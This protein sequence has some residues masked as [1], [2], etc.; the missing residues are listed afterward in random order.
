MTAGPA[1]PAGLSSADAESRLREFGP[2]LPPRA[3]PRSFVSRVV[4]QLRDPT[5]LLL[6][7]AAVVVTVLGDVTDAGII[8]AVVVLNTAIGVVQE[9]RAAT[10]LAA[11]DELSAPQATVRRDG[12]L[13]RV[14]GADVVPGD[15]LR[16]EA[17]DIVA[18]DGELTAAAGLQV[19]ESAMTGES[20]PV[21]RGIGEPVLGGTVVTR[22]RGG[23]VVTRTGAD[24][25]L[26]RIAT[27]LLATG[28][29]PTPL[30]VRL[31]RLSRQLVV[32]TLALAALVLG[33][34]LLRGEPLDDMVIL[35]VS[36]AVAAI[37]E[38][39]PAVVSIALALGAYRM[40]RHSAL[41]RR[42]PAVETLGSVTVLA[43]DKTGTLTE[44]RMVVQ[45][46]WTPDGSWLVTGRGYGADGELLGT[47]DPATLD[48]MMRDLVL[49]NDARID[50]PQAGEWAVIGDPMEASLLVA[51]TK[52]DGSVLGSR[53]A[54]P[55]VDEVPFDSGTKQMTTVHRGADSWLVVCKGAPEA[56]LDRL[57]DPSGAD[58]ARRIAG[59]L[60]ARGF[61]VLAV[62][63]AS[64]DVSPGAGELNSGLVLR[65]LA[66]LS[67]PARE[68]AREVV[69]ACRAAGIR[70]VM[71]T[72]DHPATARAIAEELTITREG[73]EVADGDQV[74]RG[75]HLDRVDRIG[76]YARTQPENKVDI[77]AAWQRR[78][79]VVAMTGDGV[80]DAPA[81]RRADIGIAMG[82]RGTEVARQAADLVLADDDLRTVVVAVGEGRRIYA[83]IR[84]FL[85]YGLSGGLA[86]VLVLVV[87]PFVG[88]ALPLGPAQ[89][90]WI[91][92]VTHGLP[93]VA[94][95]GEPMDP[96]DM[97]RPSP[98]PERSVLGRGLVTQILATGALIAAVAVVA[99]LT[100]P[101]ADA[102]QTWV[103]LS[104]G[105]AQLGVALALR[106]PRSGPAW[107]SR[108][109]EGAVVLAGLFQVA[110]VVWSPLQRLLGTVAISPVHAAALLALS[111]I[112]GVALALR[113][114]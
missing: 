62:A 61:R 27:S 4:G 104:L 2:N 114:R 111:A 18:A 70:T 80:N 66:A 46:L 26:G 17:G 36:L 65:G 63:D 14:S 48:L 106:A 53:G 45:E 19:D 89:I 60:A 108:G 30:Q 91:N 57:A 38:S 96:D 79:D 54:W 76:V 97:R 103:F 23:A 40:A 101:D 34:G 83:N 113:R 98:P 92:M 74:R 32:L 110:A 10:A 16:L 56:V 90:L 21:G 72:G 22:G 107:R 42:L 3:R 1:D 39:L 88:M 94:F 29:R 100:C 5:I 25:G 82:E 15:L 13:V 51:A 33:L 59:E 93:G 41:V 77:V 6:I 50:G 9:M 44:G 8:A 87:G 31:A 55:R 99:G 68:T 78:G 11:L 28:I 37:P 84:R 35:A 95:G 81:L 47:A 43:S 71:I 85:R 75:E 102:V 109:L 7:A 64:Y 112:P 49:C 24:S 69:E 73:P 20:V 67:D 12:R 58:E 105:L 86:E 52:H